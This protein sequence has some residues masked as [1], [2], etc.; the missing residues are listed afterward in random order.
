MW[1][2]AKLI[3][4]W[5]WQQCVSV[6]NILTLYLMFIFLEQNELMKWVNHLFS[7]VYKHPAESYINLWP[8]HDDLIT[9]IN[10][11][12]WPVHTCL[13]Y[14]HNNRRNNK[15]RVHFYSAPCNYCHKQI[16][17]NIH[18]TSTQ[19]FMRRLQDIKGWFTSVSTSWFVFNMSKYQ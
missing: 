10:L 12:R 9:R 13:L 19:W 18:F 15:V 17:N 4:F 2:W 11:Q 6:K 5:G 14:G 8:Q 1:Y 7:F 16:H 3:N